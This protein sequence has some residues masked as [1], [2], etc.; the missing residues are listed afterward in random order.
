LFQARIRRLRYLL[1]FSFSDKYCT[2]QCCGSESERI[3]IFWLDPNP[4]K[5]FG[6]GFGSRHCCKI[7]SFEKNRRSNDIDE[8]A[9]AVDILRKFAD[10]TKVGHA[11][12]DEDDKNIL[13][14]ALDNLTEWSNKWGMSFNVKK[15]KVVHF[16]RTS[17]KYSYE[18]NGERLAEVKEERDIGV[19]VHQSLK[20]SKQCAK[21]AATARMVLGQVTRSFHYRD[22]STFVKLYKT[23]IRPHLEFCTPAWS[24]WSI[25]DI[26]TLERVQEKFVNMVSGLTGTTYDEKLAELHLDR[27]EC[28]R[29]QFDIAMVHKIVHGH[30]D[31]DMDHW[32]EKFTGDRLTRAASDP[33]N[34]KAKGGRLDIR[35]GFFSNRVVSTWNEIPHDVKKV[36]DPKKF[37][38]F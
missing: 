23:Y 32:F 27:L 15:C 9:A 20:P 24:P 7:K 3:H 33:L 2:G 22:R 19:E 31:L 18:M 26:K 8:A 13:Q 10:D 34:I 29:Q 4:K 28:R 36:P 25:T 5:K 11:V 30:G 6:F 1:I 12:N 38:K 35:T 37:K 17:K 14:E 21:A 16:G